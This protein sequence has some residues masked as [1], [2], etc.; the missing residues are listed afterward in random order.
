ML[1]IVGGNRTGK[2]ELAIQY[3]VACA[4]GRDAYVDTPRGRFYW[5]REWLRTNELPEELIPLGP[6]RV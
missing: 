4:A 5:V 6:G 2:S 1:A 3:A